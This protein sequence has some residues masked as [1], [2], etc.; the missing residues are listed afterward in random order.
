VDPVSNVVEQIC[1]E[2]FNELVRRDFY[3][4]HKP[5]LLVWGHGDVA[6]ER[7]SAINGADPRAED[8]G[9]AVAEGSRCLDE[10]GSP[11]VRHEIFD[12]SPYLAC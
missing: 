3:K 12:K 7:S 4:R 5:N 2:F 9:V 11:R 6:L 1:V 10:D 8:K